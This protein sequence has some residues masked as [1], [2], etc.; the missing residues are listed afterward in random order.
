MCENASV[1]TSTKVSIST[2]WLK[3]EEALNYYFTGSSVSLDIFF[4]EN[5]K[6]SSEA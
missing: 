6:I 5:S 3:F 4:V 2:L 1:D